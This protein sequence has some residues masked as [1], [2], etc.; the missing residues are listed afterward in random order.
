MNCCSVLQLSLI[1]GLATTWTYFL[2]LSLSS[3]I[4]I[5]S[6]THELLF[7]SLAVLDPRVGHNMDVLSPFISVLC[8]SDWLFHAWTVALFF[9]RPWSE[10]WPQHGGTSLF[11]SVLC[12][13]DW[14]LQPSSIQ[15][16]ATTWKYFLHLS[17]SSV[18]LI[19]SSTHGLLFCS[20]AVL[21]PRIGHNMEV[22]SPS[23]SVVCHSDWSWSTSLLRY[24]ILHCVQKMKTPTFF[25]GYWNK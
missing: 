11:I 12:H 25:A 23:I 17:L 5:D 8:H 13:S 4:L 24:C 14:L 16:L 21:D 1:R 18:I 7:C 22:L 19:D 20:L 2:H 9:S 10:G 6:S 3:V 15:G